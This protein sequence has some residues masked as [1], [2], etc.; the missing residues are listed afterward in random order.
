MPPAIH[1]QL[2][3]DA[4]PA[5][6]AF[7][8][9]LPEQRFTLVADENTQAALGA[10][11]AAALQAAG[12]HTHSIVLA[13]PEVVADEEH[14]MQ[15]FV[16]APAGPQ[17]FVAVGSGTLT[18]ITRYASYRTGQ[19]FISVPTAASVDGFIS[20]GAPL[21]LRGLKDTYITQ[22]PL[23]VFAD[24]NTLAA[25]PPA[26]T[27]AGFGDIVGKY[28]S[29]AD[30]R[31]AHLIW[32]EPFDAEIEARVRGALNKCVAAVGDI[33]A[34]TPAGVRALM[35][36]LLESGLGMVECGSSR[37]ASGSE[38]HCSHF[39]EMRLL[40]ER[41]PA[42]LHGA[43]VGYATLLIAAQ[44][45][46]LRELSR[47][48]VAALLKSAEWPT[49]AA[50]SAEMQATYGSLADELI[51]SQRPY[52]D[53]PPEQSAQ[54][55]QKIVDQWEEIQS[56]LASVPPPGEIGALL[57]QAGAPTTREELGLSA[58]VVEEALRC[59]HYLRPRFTV[60]K[61]LLLLG[62]RPVL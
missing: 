57:A 3:D 27:A 28:T 15:V 23:A 36:A 14:L 5:L 56:I 20:L 44:Y 58:D 9:A 33:A 45:A 48:E 2:E 37:P 53:L 32:G 13:G 55:K 6:A 31:L 43:K 10:R 30:W 49:R 12:L 39:W 51:R 52:L 8:R 54:I 50:Q 25:A 60:I 34:Q 18:D 4:L 62:M 22:P 61:L 21:I 42:L 26:L 47:V 46:R 1:I 38:H 59:G 19:R 40:Q 17:V 16:Q 35:E 11:V 29:L 24:L 41:R 7:C